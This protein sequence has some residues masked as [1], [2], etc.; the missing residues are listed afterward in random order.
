M[1]S[2]RVLLASAG[3]LMMRGVFAQSG[4]YPSRPIRWIVPF[5]PGG[6]ADVVARLLAERLAGVFGQP[7]IVENRGGAGGLIGTDVGAK[8]TPDGYTW[9]LGN[10][11][12]ITMGIHL[13]KAPYDPKKDF[14]PVSLITRL[15]LLLVANPGL[16][17]RTPEELV[18]AGRIPGNKITL[19]NAGN[20][21]ISH[22]AA[23]YFRSTTGIAVLHVPYKGVQE[24]LTDVIAGRVDLFF[25]AIGSAL[26]MFRAGK[27]KILAIASRQRYAGLPDV[28][29][30]AESGQAGFEIDGWHGLL[31]PKGTPQPLVTRVSEEVA[32][33][34]RTPALLERLQAM[35]LVPVGSSPEEFAHLIATDSD[36]W[37]RLIRSSGI[38]S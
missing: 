10:D 12:P 26:P 25:T 18:A 29:T 3:A 27:L 21:S 36:K 33:A 9:L 1:I 6:G 30:I 23:E 5:T 31:M 32:R 28:P 14:A 15:Q 7:V 35:G 20:G 22:I 16:A 17:A 11:G 2:R 4:P 24:A 38:K 19:A 13:T 37:G 8:A 34:L